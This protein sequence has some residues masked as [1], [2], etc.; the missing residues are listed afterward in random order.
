MANLVTRNPYST[1]SGGESSAAEQL[2][3][4]GDAL[5]SVPF[6]FSAATGELAALTTPLVKKL[7]DW[8]F[9][10]DLGATL[11]GSDDTQYFADAATRGFKRIL[12]PTG[13]IVGL[14]E[15]ALPDGCQLEAPGKNPNFGARLGSEPSRVVGLS[16]AASV[17]DLSASNVCV[18]EGITAYGYDHTQDVFLLGGTNN[19]LRFCTAARGKIGF[20]KEDGA[21]PTASHYL[22]E[23]SALENLW[24]LKNLRD[25]D[26]LSGNY[27]FNHSGGMYFSSTCS[28]VRVSARLAWNGA[29]GRGALNGAGSWVVDREAAATYD[30]GPGLYIDGSTGILCFGMLI[31]AN[32][33]V[34]LRAVAAKR[35]EVMGYWRRN[36]MSDGGASGEDAHIYTKNCF[37][38]RVG[39]TA[40]TEDEDNGGTGVEKPK[41]LICL[42]EDDLGNR[43][44]VADFTEWEGFT[45]APV[46]VIGETNENV[47]NRTEFR[48]LGAPDIV[49]K[50]S[51][52]AALGTTTYQIRLPK[53]TRSID[54]GLFQLEVSARN[55]GAPTTERSAIFN[56]VYRSDHLELSAPY[57]EI[58]EAGYLG[59][60]SGAGASLSVGAPSLSGA[61]SLSTLTIANND[62]TNSQIFFIKL[63]CRPVS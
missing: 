41:Y 1:G 42:S 38:L 21:N 3:A 6:T 16:G 36:G 51:A 49:Y 46:Q 28:N 63:R 5:A 60:G 13:A 26:I 35:C 37:G 31:D 27:S 48:G 34:G 20:G 57:G 7:R 11:D 8:V 54:R 22:L 24:G 9:A 14:G 18:V 19:S 44:F 55:S 10:D 58:G 56:G 30:E 4:T 59:V 50:T 23:C 43:D 47:S 61:Y 15:L 32:W 2:L 39:G 25:S 17:F 52:V 33:T 29:G 12:I 53:L 40:K 45:I 62:D